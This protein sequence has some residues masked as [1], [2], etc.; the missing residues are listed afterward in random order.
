MHSPKKKKPSLA[1]HTKLSKCRMLTQYFCYRAEGK[2]LNKGR[3]RAQMAFYTIQRIIPLGSTVS[4]TSML[5][6]KYRLILLW[7]V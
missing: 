6:C 1:I 7:W 5:Y 2:L 4:I 3:N